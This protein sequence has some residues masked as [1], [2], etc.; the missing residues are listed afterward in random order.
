MLNPEL[1]STAYAEHACFFQTKKQAP[2]ALPHAAG[3]IAESHTHLTSLEHIDPALALA[4]AA[5]AGVRF[6]VTVA[7]PT[8]DARDADALLANLA[9]WQAGCARILEGW[10]ATGVLDALGEMPAPPVVRLLVGCH[11]HNAKDFD[12]E[13][14][15]SMRRLLAEPICCGIGEIGLDYHYD[16]SPRETQREVFREQLELACELD[17]SLSLHVREAHPEAAQIM[18]ETGL[19]ADG[20][21]VLHCFDLDLATAETFLEMGCVLGIGGAV[22]FKRNDA[23]RDAVA[24]LPRARM[25]FETDAP[26]MAPEPLR[27]TQCEPAYIARTAEFVAALRQE[28]CGEGPADTYRDAYVLARHIFERPAPLAAVRA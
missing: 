13:A 5:V 2:L 1:V 22:S 21:V 26:Y 17:A 14:R 16:L 9:C 3:P 11:P 20:G 19:P 12:G 18:R 27:G 4:R 25:V 24:A 6:L 8:D 28:R 15:A 10:R 23:T 7:D